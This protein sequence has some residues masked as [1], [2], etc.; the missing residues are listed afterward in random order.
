MKLIKVQKLHFQ[1]EKSDKIYEVELFHLQDD[2]YIVNFRYGRRGKRLTEGTKTVFPVPKSSAEK[3]FDELVFS[4]T[5]KGYQEVLDYG[6]PTNTPPI[7]NVVTG[8]DA[9]STILTYLKQLANG[10]SIQLNWKRSRIIWRAGELKITEAAP[11]INT[12]LPSLT[13]HEMYAA[14]WYLGRINDRNSHE[15]LYNIPSVKGEKW[16]RIYNA[17]LVRRN[18]RNVIK[19]YS[20]FIAL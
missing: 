12:L 20:R 11:F 4:K 16:E 14:I 1:D 2:E 6:T 3:V 7:S 15:I 9:K 5:K 8:K 18:D 17:A 10:E 13:G 19:K